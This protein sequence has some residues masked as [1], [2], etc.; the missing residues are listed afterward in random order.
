M[1]PP[2]HRRAT[3]V[4]PPCHHRATASPAPPTPPPGPEPQ[5][6]APCACYSPSAFINKPPLITAVIA[7]LFH[8]S[9]RSPQPHAGCVSGTLPLKRH[10]T[11]NVL[12]LCCGSGDGADAGH[13]VP[14]QQPRL[15]RRGLIKGPERAR[16]DKGPAKPKC[17][18]SLHNWRFS[19]FKI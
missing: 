11:Q 5:D 19:E 14:L 6:R 18:A 10:S 1:P 3:T 17:K 7:K 12:D 13:C 8:G 15:T 16:R 2:C 9:G 4:P